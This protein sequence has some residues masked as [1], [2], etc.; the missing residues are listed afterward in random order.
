MARRAGDEDVTGPPGFRQKTRRN[1]FRNSALQNPKIL[2]SD[3]QF[4][5]LMA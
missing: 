2:L 5:R 1:R 4:I 3:G